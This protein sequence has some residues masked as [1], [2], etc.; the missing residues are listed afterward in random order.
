[1][2]RSSK[3]PTVEAYLNKNFKFFNKFYFFYKRIREFYQ[4]RVLL[5]KNLFKLF[6]NMY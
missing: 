6:E 3:Y 2:N 5:K 4:I 1:M